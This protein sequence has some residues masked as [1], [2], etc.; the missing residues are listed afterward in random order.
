MFALGSGFADTADLHARWRKLRSGRMGYAD[1]AHPFRH[2]G[3]ADLNTYKMFLETAYRLLAGNGRLGFLVPSGVYS[4]KGS[5]A[6]RTLFLDHSQWE[7]LFGF[8]NREA[9]FDIHRSFKFAPIIVQKGGKTQ[10]IHTAFM[11]RTL[12]DWEDGEKYALDY[13]RDRVVQFSPYTKALLEIR[14]EADLGILERLYSNSVLL[15]DKGPD[16]WHLRY[17]RE[18]DM[19]NDAKKGL[20]RDRAKWEEEG[21][22]PDEYGHWLQGGWQPYDGPRGILQRAPDLVVSRDG[23]QAIFVDA[24]EGV[25]LPLYEGRMIGQFD[26]SQKAW[27]SGKGRA[28]KWDLIAFSDKTV[29]P[30]YLMDIETYGTTVD[31]EGHVKAARGLKL[32]FM[33]VSS[34]TNQRTMIASLVPDCPCGN[35]VPVLARLGDSRALTLC[36]VLDSFTYDY[37]FRQRLGG[38]TLNWFIVAETCT[39]RI[40]DESRISL[41]SLELAAPHESFEGMEVGHSPIP[42][43]AVPLGHNPLRT[44]APPVHSRCCRRTSLRRFR[45]RF[46]LH[47]AGLRPSCQRCHE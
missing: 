4:D 34:A 30:Q 11:H 33:D 24:I 46:P 7:W 22:Q 21:Y 2:Q 43:L 12:A 31:R 5:T 32:G 45:Q 27:I 37:Q 40:A 38:T 42:L 9:I 17:A 10:A 28:A 1:E 15:A 6:L 41:L 23:K 35:K 13:P 47:P 8:E 36:A 14:G 16:S 26:F 39:P 44:I 20:F 18:F 29:Q 19:T 3:S 25:A